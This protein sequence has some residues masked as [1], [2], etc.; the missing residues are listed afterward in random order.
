[1]TG[2]LLVGATQCHLDNNNLPPTLHHAWLGFVSA[3]SVALQRLTLPLDA[4]CLPSHTM[5]AQWTGRWL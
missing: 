4:H 1:M 3:T 2:K 5:T